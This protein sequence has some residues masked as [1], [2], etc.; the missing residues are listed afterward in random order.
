[1]I[2]PKKIADITMTPKKRKDSKNN[3]FAFYIGR[4]LSYILTIPFLY[5]NIAPNTVSVLSVIPSVVGF[6]LM[7]LG[8]N[9]DTLLL[10]WVCFFL[11]NLL[12][13]VDGNI[14][15]YKKLSSPI[16]SVYDAMGGYAATVLSFFAWGWAASHKNGIIADIIFIPPEFYIVIGALSGIFTLFP[17]LIM[18]RAITSLKNEKALS[19]LMD[20]SEYGIVKTIALNITSTSGF[21]QVFMLVSIIFNAMDLFTLSYCAINFLIMAVALKNIL[22]M[23]V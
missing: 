10:G 12:D 19:G 14:A 7:G 18:H 3:Y 2:T 6:L 4:P 17:R 20:K 22:T 8:E 9:V 13:G 11:W 1:M 23:K 15:R 5:T 21:L 16:G